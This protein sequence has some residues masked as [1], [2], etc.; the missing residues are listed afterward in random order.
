M[1]FPR[2]PRYKDSGVEWLGVV[3]EHWELIPGRRLFEQRRDPALETDEQLSATQKYGVI[4]QNLFMKLEDQKV[5]LALSGTDNFKH[6]NV[7]EFV[8]SLRS[9]QGG[10]EHSSYAGCVSP[11]YTVLRARHPIVSRYWVYALKSVGYIAELQSVTEGIRDG[12]NISY[13]QFAEI[14]LG[15]PPVLEQM[16]VATFLDRE[17]EK[18]DAL[19]AEQQR[20]IELLKEKRQAV[21]SHAVTKGLNPDAPIKPSGIDWLGDIPAHWA[22]PP[23]FARYDAVLGKM[24]DEKQATGRYLMPYL[25]NADVNWDWINTT[26]LPSIDIEPD[27]VDRYGLLPGDVL[28]CE[29]GAGVGQTAVWQGQLQSCAFQKALHRLRARSSEENPRYLYYCI[30]SAVEGGAVLATGNTSTIPHFTGEKV[31]RLRLPCPPRH[32]QDRI[33]EYV[34]AVIAQMECLVADAERAI[35]LLQERRAALISAAVTGKIDV[36]SVFDA[37]GSAA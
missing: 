37:E 29:G 27:E 24:L 9:F 25:R 22:L 11:A 21:I 33:V 31:R 13:E 17:V 19:I 5:T 4:P 35:A 18:I 26:D 2:Y 23:L 28:I 20:L 32:E 36:R 16:A 8:I 34:D 6:V 30:R 12:K 14:V 1:S 3:P 7:D 15:C 10:L